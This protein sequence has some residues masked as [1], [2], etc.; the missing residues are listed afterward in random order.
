M[1]KKTM[2]TQSTESPQSATVQAAHLRPSPP[3]SLGVH[4]PHCHQGD[5]TSKVGNETGG[6]EK[7]KIGGNT[8]I[9]ETARYLPSPR[10]TPL[11]LPCNLRYG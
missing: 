7:K 2:R 6:Q 1:D 8:V 5:D 11:Y 3:P 4:K 10:R 9:R